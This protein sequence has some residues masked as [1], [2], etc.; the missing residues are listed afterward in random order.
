MESKKNSQQSHDAYFG[1]NSD[2]HGEQIVDFF[3]TI[4]NWGCED[5]TM[6]SRALESE[7]EY[8]QRQAEI[9][10]FRVLVI[11]GIVKNLDRNSA[12]LLLTYMNM[13]EEQQE[14]TVCMADMI[15]Y[16]V[17]TVKDAKDKENN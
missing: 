12:D 4:E 3:V 7:A 2:K 1:P 16:D 9:E 15:A 13:V 17:K 6:V 11:E 5:R 8:I 10:A 14:I